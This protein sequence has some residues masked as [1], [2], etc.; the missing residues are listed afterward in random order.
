MEVAARRFG[1][2][3]PIW[4]IC[5]QGA[6]LLW[7]SPQARNRRYG[8]PSSHS[9]DGASA[10]DRGVARLRRVAYVAGIVHRWDLR[11]PGL[12]GPGCPRRCPMAATSHSS[13]LVPVQP[14]FTDAE[15][16]ALAGF[17]AGYRGLTP[18]GLHARPAPHRLV[19]C[20]IRAAVLGPP[21][22]YRDLR[23]GTGSTGPCP[24]HRDPAAVHHRRVLQVRG[25]GGDPRPLP[26]RARPAAEAGRPATGP[27]RRRPDRPAGDLSRRV[28]ERKPRTTAELFETPSAGASPDTGQ[29]KFAAAP[30]AHSAIANSQP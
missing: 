6:L 19:P 11:R 15:R 21:R 7:P 26:C 22:R 17:L 25:R 27:A 30:H 8:A 24:R 2:Q 3:A 4:V 10:T 9:R 18:R 20:P 14:L 13:S 29:G 23:P 5:T 16:L 12:P 28:H 1:G